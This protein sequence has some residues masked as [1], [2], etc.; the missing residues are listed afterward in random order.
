M[1]RRPELRLAQAKVYARAAVY[2]KVISRASDKY[3]LAKQK[4]QQEGVGTAC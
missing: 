3:F 4:G 1:N 2:R